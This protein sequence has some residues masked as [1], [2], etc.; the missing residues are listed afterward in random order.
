MLGY[1]SLHTK[2]GSQSR[3]QGR[4]GQ[5]VKR[6]SNEHS[7]LRSQDTPLPCFTLSANHGHATDEPLTQ[8]QP[9]T[10]SQARGDTNGLTFLNLTTF[11]CT[12]DIVIVFTLHYYSLFYTHSCIALG[13]EEGRGG[14]EEGLNSCHQL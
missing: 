2:Q 1:Q 4:V 9:M 5:V 7:R 3:R 10:A 14:K 13:G 11:R 6:T 12:Q 8:H